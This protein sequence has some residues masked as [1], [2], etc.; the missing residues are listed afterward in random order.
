MSKMSD[1]ERFRLDRLIKELKSK[2]GRGTELVTLY[3]PAGKRLDEV[4]SMLRQEYAQASNIKDRTTRHHVL[5][6]LTTIMQRLKM[7]GPKAPP[8]GLVVFCGYVDIGIPGRE[9]LEIHLLEPPEPVKTWLY[10]C[11]SRFYTEI[12][13]DMIREKDVYGLLV[14]DRSEAT[15]AILRGT[16][17][18]IVESITSGVPSKHHKGGQS[19][20]RFQRIIEQLAHEYYKRVGEY[21]KR[22]FLT[23]PELKGIVIGGPGPTKNE[24]FEG[25]YLDYRLKGKVL[26]LVD[27]GYSGEEGIYE[28]VKRADSLLRDARYVRERAIMQRFL[29]YLARRSEL[30]AYGEKEVREMI[31]LGAVEVLMLSEALSDKIVKAE[32]TSCRKR[33][34]ARVRSEKE[35]YELRC[36]HCKGPVKVLEERL[37]IEELIEEATKMGARVELISPNTEE[38]EML[39]K[40]FG[41]ICAILRFNPRS[42]RY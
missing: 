21:A 6:A 3:I 30:V 38:G 13:E 16:N 8:N 33:F 10:R 22:I 27:I 11:D 39:I 7:L 42:S 5:D 28:L 24:F 35:K 12:L 26:G 9:E 37:L 18:E 36:P 41:G 25:D 17:I 23:V 29:D 4:V 40:T 20:R 14:I 19:A 1:L 32:C 2:K 34:K 15:F 31:R